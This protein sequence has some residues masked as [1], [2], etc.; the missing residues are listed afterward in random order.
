MQHKSIRNR[1]SVRKGRSK[2][3]RKRYAKKSLRNR[4]TR[5]RRVNRRM[6]GRMQ[7][8]AVLPV[9]RSESPA[10]VQQTGAQNAA[11]QNRA[12]HMG[13]GR[14][15]RFSRQRKTKKQQQKGGDLFTKMAAYIAPPGQWGPIPQP[16]TFPDTNKLILGAAKIT[17]SAQANAEFDNRVKT[18]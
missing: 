10:P 1:H 5:K 9:I 18:T 6:Q 11:A 13:G 8:G 15:K 2:S 16:S 14:K 7:G 4:S 3:F 12:N 17:G